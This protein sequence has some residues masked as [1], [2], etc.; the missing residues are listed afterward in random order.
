M[1]KEINLVQTSLTLP[2]PKN[3]WLEKI[4]DTLKYLGPAFIVS[5]AYIDPGNFATNISAGSNFNYNLVWV[6]LWSNLMA[7]FLQTLSAKLGIVTGVDLATQCGRVFSR[8]VNFLLWIIMLFAVIATYMAE[9]LGSTLGLY[10]LFGIPLV[11]AGLITVCLTFV[12]VYLQRF[13][14]HM[15]ERIIISLV[16]VIG[17][18]YCLE[19]FLAKPDWSAVALHTLVP[20]LGPESI[21][22]AVGML[23]ATVMPHVI[24]LHSDLMKA[25]RTSDDLAEAKKHFRMECFDIAFAMNIAFLV[26]AAMVIIAAAVFFN[27]GPVDSIEQAHKSLAP[28]LGSL[29]S[30]AFGLAL[31]ASGLSSSTVGAMAGECMLKG[32]IGLDIPVNI[33]RAITMV[34]AIIL[35]WLGFNPM[36]MLIMSQVTL[37]FALP[38][39]VIPLL[40]ITKRRDIMGEMTNRKI[41][42]AAGVVIISLIISLN[43]VLL[44]LTF[45]A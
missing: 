44:Y 29:S 10:L 36:K 37:S 4:K 14:Q 12:I 16:A 26:N 38:A 42:N 25:R 39:A 8:P 21:L 7:I 13:G 45:S 24:Y 35:L 20:S 28:L 32:F 41:T 43:V 15:V 33:R 11:A 18:S 40:L 3:T 34:P 5:V 19:L 31:L 27:Q 17:A 9:F 2:L 30:G 1:S 23:G 22:V 6:V